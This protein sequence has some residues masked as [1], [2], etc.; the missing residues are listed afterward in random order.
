[1]DASL[2]HWNPFSLAPSI[3]V[4]LLYDQQT[5]SNVS[6]ITLAKYR[7]QIGQNLGSTGI[8]TSDWPDLVR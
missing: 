3:T 2:V 5:G 7:R 4:Q 6:Q 1:M 8:L